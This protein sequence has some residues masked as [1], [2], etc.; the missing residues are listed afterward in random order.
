MKLKSHDEIKIEL[1][2]IAS[3][4]DYTWGALSLL[5]QSV[6][7]TLYWM[8]SASS[9]TLWVE[10][11]SENL[12]IKPA[13]LWRVLTSGRYT[14]KVRG[15]LHRHGIEVPALEDLSG[16]ISPENIE[17]L[18]KLERVLPEEKYVEI[19]ER[20]FQGNAKRAELRTLWQTYRPAL[21][22]R[23]A[24]GRGVRKPQVDHENP[25]EHEFFMEATVL[26]ALKASGTSWVKHDSMKSSRLFL[27]VIT[28]DPVNQNKFSAVMT[29]LLENDELEL[30]GFKYCHP[31]T[32]IE[33]LEC[34]EVAFCDYFWIMLPFSPSFLGENPEVIKNQYYGVLC[35]NDGDISVI[36]PAVSGPSNGEYTEQTVCTLFKREFLSEY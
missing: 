3:G 16:K 33:R 5:L 20:V 12:G 30:H 10:K 27:N 19:A 29:V 8:E 2:D 9:F 18:A 34:P 14:M 22:G 36:K 1:A 6:E 35:I 25:E 21:K 7:K 28:G 17:I 24:R 15:Y 13:T 32:D 4:E 23:N 26:D 11:K 31:S